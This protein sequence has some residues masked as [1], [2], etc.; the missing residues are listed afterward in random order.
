MFVRGT[1][2]DGNQRMF[3]W[4]ASLEGVAATIYVMASQPG[5]LLIQTL[6]GTTATST[7]VPGVNPISVVLG[8]VPKVL[9]TTDGTQLS[10]IQHSH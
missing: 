5:T 8:S 6:A 3:C 7:L 10:F 4:H 1:L 9:Y 2:I